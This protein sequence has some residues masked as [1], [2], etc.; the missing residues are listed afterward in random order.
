MG[1]LGK[2]ILKQ[3]QSESLPK[4]SQTEIKELQEYQERMKELADQKKAMKIE[5]ESE[6]EKIKLSKQEIPSGNVEAKEDHYKEVAS[7]AERMSSPQPECEAEPEPEILK[8]KLK[9]R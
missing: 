8:P 4:L 5:A 9:L 2:S 3:R 7:V 1:K 6:I